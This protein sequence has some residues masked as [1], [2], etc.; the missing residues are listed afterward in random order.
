M[1]GP[2]GA[3]GHRLGRVTEG[4]DCGATAVVGIAALGTGAAETGPCAQPSTWSSA[5][6]TVSSTTPG[7]GPRPPFPYLAAPFM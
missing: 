7:L 6:S 3:A 1:A 4:G 2:T 5:A